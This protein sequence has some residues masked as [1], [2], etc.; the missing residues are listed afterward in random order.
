MHYCM[1]VVLMPRLTKYCKI[2][3]HVN[4]FLRL[5]RVLKENNIKLILTVILH[6]MVV[7]KTIQKILKVF[8]WRA[9]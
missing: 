8:S 4:D 5:A 2:S 3:H 9:V 1:V 7:G 6:V